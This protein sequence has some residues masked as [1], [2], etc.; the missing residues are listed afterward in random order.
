MSQ[1][2]IQER[3]MIKLAGALFAIHQTISVKLVQTKVKK[4]I[5]ENMKNKKEY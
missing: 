3:I 2:I 5:L 1:D 4:D